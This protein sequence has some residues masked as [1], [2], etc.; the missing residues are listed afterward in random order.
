MSQTP[1]SERFSEG[2]QTKD[3]HNDAAAYFDL[4]S[5]A[6]NG[7]SSRPNSFINKAPGYESVEA[8]DI[9]EQTPTDRR[10]SQLSRKPLPLNSRV[11]SQESF[12]AALLDEQQRQQERNGYGGG[13]YEGARVSQWGIGWKTPAIMVALYLMGS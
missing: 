2:R 5:M 1:L 10:A 11:Y 7:L 13:G 6:L 12:T 4:S 8:Y 9:G 3:D